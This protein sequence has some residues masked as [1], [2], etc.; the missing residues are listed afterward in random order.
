[1][2]NKLHDYCKC[3]NVTV[4]VNKAVAMVCKTGPKNEN[5]DLFY[6]HEKFKVVSKFTYLGVT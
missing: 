3:W 6:N 2:L 1:L 5:V 4:N